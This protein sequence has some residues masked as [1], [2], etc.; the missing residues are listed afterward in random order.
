MENGERE[1]EKKTYIC[2]KKEHIHRE[3]TYTHREGK[4]EYT[5]EKYEGRY[6]Q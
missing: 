6:R 1:A 4:R 2:L 5:H 3:Q